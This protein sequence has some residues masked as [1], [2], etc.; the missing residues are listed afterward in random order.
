VDTQDRSFGVLK[1]G[2]V[3][4]ST[5]TEP[6]QRKATARG[7]RVMRYSVQAS[8]AARGASTEAER[9]I[10]AKLSEAKPTQSPKAE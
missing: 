4:V 10:L 1:K 9:W 5:L 3:L 2:G 6:D 8:A 7:V